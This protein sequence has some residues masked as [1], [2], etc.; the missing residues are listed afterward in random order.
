[1]AEESHGWRLNWADLLAAAMIMALRI[2]VDGHVENV[3]CKLIELEL[4]INQQIANINPI[5]PMR[6]YRTACRAAVPALF[7]A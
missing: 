3:C 6:L 2:T 5:S 4:I 1:M 7:R